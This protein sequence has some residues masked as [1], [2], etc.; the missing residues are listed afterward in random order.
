MP[1]NVLT[2]FAFRPRTL[3]NVVSTTTSCAADF[4][5]CAAIALLPERNVSAPACAASADVCLRKPRRPIRRSECCELIRRP[6]HSGPSPGS[7]DEGA[8]GE[9]TTLLRPNL[10]SR[11]N[12]R[13]Q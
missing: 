10:E 13:Q 3:P 2:P 6:I 4:A 9:A 1:L 7:A 11:C 12:L 5:G 8:G